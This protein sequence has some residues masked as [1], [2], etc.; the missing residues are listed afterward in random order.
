METDGVVAGFSHRFSKA[1]LV[2][3]ISSQVWELPITTS[4]V[5]VISVAVETCVP[6]PSGHWKN[7]LPRSLVT[8]KQ[9]NLLPKYL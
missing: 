6:F 4:T 7:P 2:L 5:P 3:L 9:L 1:L 8:F